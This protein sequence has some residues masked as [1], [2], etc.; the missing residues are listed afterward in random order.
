M[1][2]TELL[3]CPFCSE[4]MTEALP[5]SGYYRHAANG[6]TLGGFEFPDMFGAKRDAWNTRAALASQASKGE[7][8]PYGWLTG[9]TYDDKG[10]MEFTTSYEAAK[11][12]CD[13]WNAYERGRGNFD[14]NDHEDRVPEPLYREPV[15]ASKGAVPEGWALVPVEPTYEMKSAGVR[16]SDLEYLNHAAD[17]WTEMLA[18]APAAPSPAQPAPVAWMRAVGDE[19]YKEFISA[20]AKQG[21]LDANPNSHVAAI[22][23]TPL[24][25]AQPPADA[26]PVEAKPEITGKV[27]WRESTAEWVLELEGKIDGVGFTCRHTQ[28]SNIRRSDVPGLP[29]L[30][31]AQPSPAQG[32]ALRQQTG[33]MAERAAGSF[34][35]GWAAGRAAGIEQVTEWLIINGHC[36]GVAV[37]AARRALAA[38]KE[39]V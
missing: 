24:Y 8:K 38:K 2:N 34:K 14:L 19:N 25:A 12:E 30:Y 15:Q 11:R 27:W 10:Y 22:Y 6:C 29:E 28:S 26:A 5:G 32:E 31:V 16:H 7:Q 1:N 39:G 3:P 36:S 33:A 17:V 20:E 21:F 9:L 18:H 37:D 4:Q 23:K 13:A 35:D